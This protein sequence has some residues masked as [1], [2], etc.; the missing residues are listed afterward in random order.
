MSKA[1]E[2]ALRAVFNGRAGC[3]TALDPAT[4]RALA[5]WRPDLVK[6]WSAAPGSVLKPLSASALDPVDGVVACAHRLT[7][8]G[9]NLDCQHPPRAQPLDAATALAVSCNAW[10]AARAAAMDPRA[11]ARVL[12]GADFLPPADTQALQLLALGVRGIRITPGWLARAY[13][14]LLREAP[15]AIRRGLELAVA[16][17]TARGA[18]PALGGKTG[19]SREAAWFAGYDER[20]LLVIALPAGTGPGDAAPLAGEV[21]KRCAR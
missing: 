5:H 18:Q 3:A 7:I 14:R 1:V 19:T 4:G 9:V 21:F 15:A 8:A 20:L 17:G 10:I 11:L 12:A 6:N 16:E 13:L 2:A